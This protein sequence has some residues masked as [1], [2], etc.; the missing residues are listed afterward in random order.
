MKN[1]TLIAFILLIVLGCGSIKENVRPDNLSN[2]IQTSADDLISDYKENELAADEKF[3]NKSVLVTGVVS[4]IADV[5]GSL[6]VD[7][8]SSRDFEF[9]SVKCSFDKSEKKALS[10]LKTN[11]KATLQGTVR[12]K[13]AN[14][15]VELDNCKVK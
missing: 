1:L 14:L 12:G 15:F 10:K 3:L 9:L 6:S 11:K 13:T 2:P 5:Y 7:M 4:D 8:S